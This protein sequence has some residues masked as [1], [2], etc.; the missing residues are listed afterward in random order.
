MPAG[1]KIK[2]ICVGVGQLAERG[3]VVSIHYR[4]FLNRGDQF[5][6]TYDSGQPIQF[7]IGKRNVIAG[8]EYGVAGMRVGGRRELIVSPHLAYREDGVEGRVPANAVLRFE[9]ELLAVQNLHDDD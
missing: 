3:K 2:D 8:L 5:Q 4:G 7:E 1:L 6:S 9:V